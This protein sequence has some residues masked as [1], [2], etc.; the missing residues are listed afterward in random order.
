M[1]ATLRHFAINANDLPRAKA[2]YETLFGW[3]MVPWGPPGFYLI[4]IDGVQTGS[5]QERHELIAGNRTNSFRLSFA[6]DDP[7]ATL[8]AAKA[9]GGTVLMEPYQIEGGPEV[10]YLE[11]TE[12]NIVGIGRYSAPKSDGPPTLR[13]FAI[14]ADDVQRGKA[15]YESVFGWS[16]TPWGPPNFYQC[17]N[18][19][20]GL[21]GALQERRELVP[22]RRATS[23][24]TT[25]AVPDIRATLAMAQRNGGK[26][27]MQP[28]RIDGVGEIGY[29][30]DT[31]GNMCGL[32]QY[33]PG[34][35]SGQGP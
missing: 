12:G 17:R 15:F 1:P 14:N 34:L 10:G 25:F 6:V 27:L 29:F 19:G 3:E 16:F 8:A 4:A 21:L 2:F 18:A 13:H 28:Y 5:L 33:V 9:N 23:L 32:A 24:E 7:Y 20:E 22:G 31:E 30:E 11:D 35:W 26:I